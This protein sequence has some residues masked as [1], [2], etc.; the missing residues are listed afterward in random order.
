MQ[1]FSLS[2]EDRAKLMLTLGSGTLAA[3]T[4]ALRGYTFNWMSALLPLGISVALVAG[5]EIYRT[6]RPEP[7][8][9]LMMRETAWLLLF[10]PVAALLSNVLITLNFPGMDDWLTAFD[11]MIGFDWGSYYAFFTGRPL[12]GFV[13][14]LI[15]ISVLP[16]LAIAIIVLSM[17]GRGERAKE[18][19]MAAMLGVLLAIVISTLLPASGALA[20]FR[21]DESLLAHRPIVDL[22]YK[23]AYFDLRAGL[24]THFDFYDLRGLI[25]FPSYHAVLS[26][27]ISLSFR[28]VPKVFWPILI[29]NIAA[30]LTTPVEGGHDLASSIGGTLVGIASLLAAIIWRRDL[31]RRAD[32]PATGAERP[33]DPLVA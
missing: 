24:I 10:S 8:F 17:M 15:Y 14:A 32:R 1:A 23:Q 4:M 13:A 2:P 29:L 11:R 21:P 3:A 12:V 25:A 26:I 5:A 22:D 33:S 31:N 20:Y 18:L 27:L 19:S 9:Y 7:R 28:G 6:T 16:Q 30:I